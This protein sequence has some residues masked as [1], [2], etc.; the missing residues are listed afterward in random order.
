[1]PANS[2]ELFR[3]LDASANRCREGLRVLEDL[4]RFQWNDARFSREVKELR[5]AAATVLR[6][7]GSDSW[8]QWRNT[9]G[10]VGTQITTTLEA[11]RAT[12]GDL[13]SANSKR[14]QEALRSL[15]EFSKLINPV[16]A[17][18]LEQL[19]YRA[20]T[21]EQQMVRLSQ[22][23]ARIG[24]RRLYLLLTESLCRLSWEEVARQ[25]LAGGVDIIQLREKSLN[26]AELL[27]RARLLRE[28]TRDAGA[29]LI[30][31]DR[32]DIALLS[33]ADGVH[34][35]QEDLPLPDAR[36]LGGDLLIGVSTHSIDQ[37]RTSVEDGAGYVGLG[38]TFPTS[39]KT[40]DQF[41]GLAYLRAASTETALPSFAI[42]GITQNNMAQVV[43]T[44]VNRIAVSGVI[45][46][47]DSPLEVAQELAIE[48]RRAA[49]AVDST[50]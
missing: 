34:L 5:H 40:F 28:L 44:G 35:G 32:I 37:L 27:R 6:E 9:P 47:A 31:N 18:T 23:F 24:D 26:D 10:D 46:S 7:L 30:I 3:T 14:V 12:I 8:I 38:P 1:M 50:A 11:S 17:A 2:P 33:D 36:K 22:S 48:L 49:D 16:A 13:I 43:E 21:L 45:C 25:A 15:S 39:T 42:G 4:V 20:Y 41:A 29:L 19:R